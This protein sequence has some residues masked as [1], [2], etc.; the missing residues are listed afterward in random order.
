M[1]VLVIDRLVDQLWVRLQVV[2]SFIVVFQWFFMD[3]V[4]GLLGV[5]LVMFDSMVV[6]CGLQKQ[7]QVMFVLMKGCSMLLVL[8]KWYWV[9]SVV[10]SDLMVFSLLMFLIV[11]VLMM[12]CLKGVEIGRLMLMWLVQQQVMLLMK[13]DVFFILILVL[14]RLGV[15]RLLFLILGLIWVVLLQ[16]M[17][18]LVDCVKVLLVMNRVVSVLR[19]NLVFMGCF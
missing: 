2:F 4:V 19:R 18:L 7:L 11:L 13:E 14:G 3:R 6:V 16:M 12:L 8:L 1:K 17:M 5:F 10:G 9:I 15:V